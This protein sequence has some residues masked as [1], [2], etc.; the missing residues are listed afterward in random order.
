MRG[1]SALPWGTTSTCGII[2]GRSAL[3]LGKAKDNNA[4]CAVGPFIRLFD[5]TFTLE[6]IRQMEV[7]LDALKGKMVFDLAEV[8]RMS[9]ISRDVLDLVAQT[10]N[11]HHQ[12]PDG[13]GPVHRAPYSRPPRIAMATAWVSPT[14]W[15]I[16]F[17]IRSATNWVCCKTG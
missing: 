2:E 10:I 12:Y 13:I 14:N 16:S 9:L 11:E 5:Q 15:A 7:M 1:S 17:S 4:S 8:S 6:D 3:L